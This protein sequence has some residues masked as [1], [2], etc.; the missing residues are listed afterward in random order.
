MFEA[1]QGG[2][3]LGGSEYFFGKEDP[4]CDTRLDAMDTVYS[5]SYAFDNK[6]AFVIA[7]VTYSKLIAEGGTGC[8][9]HPAAFIG[10]L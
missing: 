8:Y 4:N 2:E 5:P 3:I 7:G 6:Y 9:T 1:V 10:Q